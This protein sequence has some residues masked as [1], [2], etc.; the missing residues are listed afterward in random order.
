MLLSASV[1]TIMTTLTEDVSDSC[2]SS[3]P[4]GVSD[5]TMVPC[6][7]ATWFREVGPRTCLLYLGRC[8]LF[9]GHNYVM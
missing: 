6:A 2:Q 8:A 7:K 9:Q 1:T 5:G 4:M 3:G